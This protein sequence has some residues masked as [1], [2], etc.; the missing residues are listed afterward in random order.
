MLRV[1]SILAVELAI[2]NSPNPHPQEHEI[3]PYR[4]GLNRRTMD[5]ESSI[6]AHTADHHGD[7]STA[8]NTFESF[9]PAAL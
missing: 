1:Q 6:G 8:L 7:S 2:Q 3:L 4:V 9:R 5:D